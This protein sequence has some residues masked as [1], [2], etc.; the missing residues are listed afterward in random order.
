MYVPDKEIDCNTVGTTSSAY[1][2]VNVT[3]LAGITNVVVDAL[4]SAN[5]TPSEDVHPAN[6]LPASGAFAV[7]VTVS[8]SSAA[9]GFAVPLLTVTEY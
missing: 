7:I 2:A 6:T 5:T 8:P 1:V 9:T 4:A 3:F